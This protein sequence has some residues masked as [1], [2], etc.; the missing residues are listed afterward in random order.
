MYERIQ[1]SLWCESNQSYDEIRADHGTKIEGVQSVR[2]M[3]GANGQVSN[4]QSTKSEMV[5]RMGFSLYILI[6]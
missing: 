5:R 6:L 3:L 1:F 2:K 4:V